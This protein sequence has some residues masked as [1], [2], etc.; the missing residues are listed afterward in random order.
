MCGRVGGGGSVILNG[1]KRRITLERGRTFC[2]HRISNDHECEASK[3]GYILAGARVRS[4][5]VL[6]FNHQKGSRLQIDEKCF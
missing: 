5:R 4:T 3:E 2:R 1:R 6:N